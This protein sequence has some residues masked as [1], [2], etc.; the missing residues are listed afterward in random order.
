MSDG[1]RRW[2][3]GTTSD[4]ITD[5]QSDR[6][7]VGHWAQDG[8]AARGVLIDYIAYCEKKGLKDNMDGMSGHAITL[9]EVKE[10]AKE[11]NI[12]FKHGDIFFLRCGFVKTW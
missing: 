9:E 5:G 12:E 8:I 7:G 1:T 4:E 10:I 6:I 11:C 3:G 2:Y